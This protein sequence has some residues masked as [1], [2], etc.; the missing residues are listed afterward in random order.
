M[1]PSDINPLK[2]Q[3]QQHIERVQLSDS[4]FK[5]LEDLMN[6]GTA[7]VETPV[8]RQRWRSLAVAAMFVVA[9]VTTLMVSQFSNTSLE[10]MPLLIAEEVVSNHLN[11]KPLEVKGGSI[12][13]V[14]GYFTKLNF[15]PAESKLRALDSLQLLGGRYCS[16]Q[17]ITAAQL[18]MKQGQNL[19]T[20]YQTEYLPEV[21]GDLPRLENGEQ[22]LVVYA[23]GV[24]VNIWV[25]KGLLFA[26]TDSPA[27]K[28]S[29]QKN[30]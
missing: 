11:L 30:K 26:L 29:M 15:M 27:V 22:P 16:L 3:L 24:K 12:N 28:K 14:R 20:Q 18:R 1:K 23:K 5:K 21:F 9:V 2:Q 4:Q 19:Q 25:E 10:D 7:P 8:E 17:G 13:K 6:Q